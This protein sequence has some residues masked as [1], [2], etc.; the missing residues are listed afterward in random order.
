MAAGDGLWRFALRKYVAEAR[1]HEEFAPNPGRRPPARMPTSTFNNREEWAVDVL[2]RQVARR[3][4]G[5]GLPLTGDI[6]LGDYPMPSRG[7]TLAPRPYVGPYGGAE[8][9]GDDDEEELEDEDVPPLVESDEGHAPDDVPA[10]LIRIVAAPTAPGNAALR[11]RLFRVRSAEWG[12]PYRG[13]PPSP[14]DHSRQRR[15]QD[16][17]E[18]F[19]RMTAAV[20]DVADSITSAQY[21]ELYNAAMALY[22]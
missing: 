1:V 8:V 7:Y 20:E 22:S 19:Q 13:G 18:K 4:S 17:Q 21:L 16:R 3:R 14:T 11:E 9:S 5:T 6:L 15:D 2:R 10:E 12:I